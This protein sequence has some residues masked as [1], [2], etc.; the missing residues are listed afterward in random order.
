MPIRVSP[1]PYTGHWQMNSSGP[2]G[3]SGHT[4]TERA[5]SASCRRHRAIA[6][7]ALWVQSHHV[8]FPLMAL[9]P[10]ENCK[11]IVK[12][13]GSLR[14]RLSISGVGSLSRPG[15]P[16]RMR[17]ARKNSNPLA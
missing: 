11:L 2:A 15:V 8:G 14:L 7:S 5:E 3:G 4:T 16:G 1:I 6:G 10:S 12:S 17:R 13:S 9:R